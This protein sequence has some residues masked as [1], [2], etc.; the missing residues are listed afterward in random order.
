MLDE[1]TIA[2]LLE[3]KR[4]ARGRAIAE[5]HRRG[6]EDGGPDDAGFW[7]LVHDLEQAPITTNLEQLEEIG[8]ELPD[9][10]IVADEELAHWLARTIK[11]LAILGVYLLRT[12]H[13]DDRA[14]YE[15]LKDR[16]LREKVRD[17]PPDCGSREWIDLGGGG[18]RETWLA[19]YAD[20]EERRAARAEGEIVPRRRGL[21]SERDRWL[22]RPPTDRGLD[23]SRSRSEPRSVE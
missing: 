21:A 8:I 11:G 6:A 10:R 15:L 16:I 3:R 20:D 19:W 17:V 7:A 1:E 12:G 18:D 13:L 9:A 2:R 14:L 23:G 22:P 4:Q 5:L